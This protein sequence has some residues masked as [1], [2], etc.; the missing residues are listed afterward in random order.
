MSGS[1][2]LT[3]LLISNTFEKVSTEVHV[4]YPGERSGLDIFTGSATISGSGTVTV[5][6]AL[7]PTI[8][9]EVSISKLES[10]L[11]GSERVETSRESRWTEARNDS[12]YFLNFKRGPALGIRSPIV[13]SSNNA[14]LSSSIPSSKNVLNN[15]K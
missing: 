10:E 6:H 7:L 11:L 14:K 8:G 9:T 3:I 4:E 1:F 15:L 2:F 13:E 12:K 5:A